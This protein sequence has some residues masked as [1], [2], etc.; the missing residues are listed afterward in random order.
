MGNETGGLR[1]T[2]DGMLEGFQIIG[3]DWRYLYVNDAAARHG[4]TEKGALLGRTMMECYPGIENTEVFALMRGSLTDG[5]SHVLEN[6]FTF[7]DGSVGHFELRIAPVPQGVRVLSIDVTARKA[8]ETAQKKAEARLRHAQRMEAIGVLAAGIAHDF[9][10]LLMV[11]LG[12]GEFALARQG[13]PSAED[14]ETMMD[15]ARSSAA[16]TRQ[17]LGY[18]RRTVLTK[19]SVDVR[20]A[21]AELERILRASAGSKIELVIVAPTAPALPV[22]VDRTQF[23][24]IVLNLVSNARDAIADRG[25]ISISVESAVLDEAAV[26]AHPGSMVGAFTVL[27]VSDT[28]TGMD[29]ET[30]ARVFEPFFT[31]KGGER[32]TGLGLATVYGIVRQHGGNLWVES[33]LGLGTTFAVYLPVAVDHPVVPPTARPPAVAGAPRTVLFADDEPVVRRLF[34]R[35]LTKAGYRVLSAADGAEAL[36]LFDVHGPSIGLL[37]TDLEMPNVHGIEVIAK[38]RA[39]RPDM[40]VISTSGYVVG[41]SESEAAVLE[42]VVRLPKPFSAS[43]LLARAREALPLG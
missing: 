22:E 6:P 20:A 16:L 18:A 21:I 35:V 2:L 4:R 43:E 17:L 31:T 38:I 42:S 8:A 25:R 36:A 33:A 24:Q 3:P 37:V 41:S 19:S 28:G 34:E 14:V 13:G 5:S 23:D 26:A 10:N 40:P 9:N 30:L 15:A 1:A 12:T 32:G 39:L 11:M 7:P 27:R 29:A